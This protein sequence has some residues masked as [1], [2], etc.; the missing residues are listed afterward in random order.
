MVEVDV[1]RERERER[2]GRIFQVRSPE[3]REDEV[4]EGEFSSE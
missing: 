2:G 4:C 3:F 1:K